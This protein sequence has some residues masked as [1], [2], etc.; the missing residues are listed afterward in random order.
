MFCCILYRLLALNHIRRPNIAA[1]III[2]NSTAARVPQTNFPAQTACVI[3][4]YIY[5]YP[6]ELVHNSSAGR[7]LS[8]SFHFDYL[9]CNEAT[10]SI[11]SLSCSRRTDLRSTQY[12]K[13]AK[14]HSVSQARVAVVNCSS[15]ATRACDTECCFLAM[16]GLLSRTARTPKHSKRVR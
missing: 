9:S 7:Q 14:Q 15:T 4:M 12:Y 16:K 10:L 13:V 1:S 5:I 2:Y 11:T 6:C 3:Y 8:S